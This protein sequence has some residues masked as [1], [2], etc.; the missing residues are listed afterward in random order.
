METIKQFL[1]ISYGSGDGSGS[2][3]G[4]GDGVK[5]FCGNTVYFVDGIQTILKV[6]H[7]NYAKG[8][9]LNY[10]LTLTPCYVAKQGDYFAHG[11]TLRAA[12]I[13]ALKK[14]E[15]NMSVEER[16]EA[17]WE[18]HNIT[19]KYLVKDFYEWHHKLTGSCKMGRDEFAK[20][21]GINLDNGRMTVNEFVTLTENACGGTIIKQLW[22]KRPNFL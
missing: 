22:E 6:V 8:F 5:T 15:E 9:L 2:G 16:I 17:F 1:S 13:A 12:Q 14:A 7:G 21:H 3:S 10:D 20:D 19:D 11:V 4:Y 18:C